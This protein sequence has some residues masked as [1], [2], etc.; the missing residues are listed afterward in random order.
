[1]VRLAVEDKVNLVVEGKVNPAVKTMADIAVAYIR[2]EGS[3]T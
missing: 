3:G 1:M 2:A